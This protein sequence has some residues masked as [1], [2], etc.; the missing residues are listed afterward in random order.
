MVYD[1]HFFR[2][3]ANAINCE[4]LAT[5]Q[6]R[7]RKDGEVFLPSISNILAFLTYTG[8]FPHSKFGPQSFF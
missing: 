5:K 4:K 2:Q 6:Q 7:V 1:C 8:S 3:L